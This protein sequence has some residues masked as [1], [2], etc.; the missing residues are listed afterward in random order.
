M[1]DTDL[2]CSGRDIPIEAVGELYDDV[3]NLI[4]NMIIENPNH[5]Y[6]C[7]EDLESQLLRDKYEE[8]WTKKGY[9]CPNENG[10]W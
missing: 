2:Y 3:I 5:Q 7:I 8:Q 1:R 6:V 4:T 10:S 9:I